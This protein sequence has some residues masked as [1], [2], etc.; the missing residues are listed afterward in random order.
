MCCL[1]VFGVLGKHPLRAFVYLFF[2]RVAAFLFGLAMLPLFL[3]CHCF[4]WKS[5]RCITNGVFWGLVSVFYFMP[6]WGFCL[7]SVDK[8]VGLLVSGLLRRRYVCVLL[9]TQYPL[10][11]PSLLYIPARRRKRLALGKGQ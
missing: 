7:W 9:A 6:A 4:V 10:S 1:C 11:H 5:G 2:Y 8:V 3:L